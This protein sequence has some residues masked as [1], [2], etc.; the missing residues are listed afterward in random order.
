MCSCDKEHHPPTLPST[1]LPNL[2]TEIL[3]IFIGG[4]GFSGSGGGGGGSGGSG[5]G[6][7]LLS[8]SAV[9]GNSAMASSFGSVAGRRV[10]SPQIT[11]FFTAT[12]VV[13]KQYDPP[14]IVKK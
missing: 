11:L 3:F 7:I 13:D 6:G 2:W 9:V 5:G 12:H 1:Q 10:V 8:P 14:Q 4:G